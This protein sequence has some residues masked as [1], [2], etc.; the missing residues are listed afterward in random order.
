MILY[1]CFNSADPL[2]QK[3]DQS[4]FKIFFC[5]DVYMSKGDLQKDEEEYF[6]VKFASSLDRAEFDTIKTVVIDKNLGAEGWN[7][8]ILLLGHITLHDYLNNTLNKIPVILTSIAD[9]QI[10]ELSDLPIKNVFGIEGITFLKHED[11]FNI[12]RNV[13]TGKSE[14]A[15]NRFLRRNSIKSIDGYSFDIPYKFDDRHQISNEWGAV[16]LA[17]NAGFNDAETGYNYP[18]TLYFKY[19]TKKY[20]AH[21]CTALERKEI[22]RKA[23]SVNKS[24]IQPNSLLPDGKLDFSN[25]K[26]LKNKRILFIDDNADKGWRST[27]Q[28]I[29]SGCKVDVKIDFEQV[30]QFG[31]TINAKPYDIVFLDL[32]LPKIISQKSS[33][34]PEHGLRLLTDLKTEHPHIPIIVFTASNKSW[35]MH[36]VLE[37]GADGIYVKESPEYAA[38]PEFSKENFESFVN[39]VIN[40]LEKYN[41]LRPYWETIQHIADDDHFT[42]LPEKQNTKFKERIVERLEMF[43]G[44]LKKGFQQR[45]YDKNRF[46]FSDYE[47]AFMTLWS[48]LNEISELYF[49][50]EILSFPVRIYNSNEY[51]QSHPNKSTNIPIWLTNWRLIN[52][53]NYYIQFYA[54]KDEKGK[55]LTNTKGYIDFVLMPT[56]IQHF[57]SDRQEESP[58]FK[59]INPEN[60]KLSKP[61]IFEQSLKLQIAFIIENSNHNQKTELYR[62]L[63]QLTSIRNKLFLT[64]GEDISEGFYSI[65][66]KDKTNI[67]PSGDVKDLFELVA[68]LLTGKELTVNI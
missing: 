33:P 26:Y 56:F 48:T 8:A 62:K 61:R 51:V 52:S 5:E 7:R 42:S 6:A 12:E 13:S 4:Y 67:T 54:Q 64:H 21:T 39:T 2:L 40:C 47:L 11:V 9:I 65:L 18:P 53:D 68:F 57:N 23:L 49:K 22:I 41:V 20:K 16:N 25:H 35:T 27:I 44:L 43:Y 66:E 1:L 14:Y 28:H 29:F 36:E 19:L 24:A 46:H 15:I 37:K 55:V 32:R 58:Y 30:N 59:T 38:D 63:L 34:I 17:R 45:Q 31:N 50:K 3:L 10:N 60:A